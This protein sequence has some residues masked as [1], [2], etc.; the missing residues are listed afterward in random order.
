M[1]ST[2][3]KKVVSDLLYRWGR[4]GVT[5][6]GLSIGLYGLC[7]VLVAFVFLANDLNANFQST[8]PPNLIIQAQSIDATLEARIAALP[9]V[10]R[11]ERRA[12]VSGR[13]EVAPEQWIPLVLFV[14]DSFDEQHVARFF[15]E[16]DSW[17]AP[18]SIAIERDS[19]FFVRT[20]LETTLRMRLDGRSPVEI[21]APVSAYTYDPGQAPSRMELAVF[22]Y[23]QRETLAAWGVSPRYDRLIATVRGATAAGGPAVNS[24]ARL[25]AS[26][27]ETIFQTANLPRPIL[28]VYDSPE[29]PHQFQLDA[30]VAQLG[31][32]A[33]VSLLLC[34]MLVVNLIDS[35]MAAERRKIG[36]MR[37]IGARSTQI[38]TDYIL[39]IGSLGLLSCLMS[40]AFAVENGQRLAAGVAAQLNFDLLSETAPYWLYLAILAIGFALPAV[41]ALL[42]IVRTVRTPVRVALA[43]SD[44]PEHSVSGGPI[45]AAL[46]PLPVIPRMAARAISTRPRRATLTAIALSLGLVFFIGALNIQTSLWSTV[47]SVSRTKPFDV[48]VSLR[49]QPQPET[50]ASWASV[51]DNLQRTETWPT[52]SATLTDNGLQI[53]NPT[54]VYGVPEGS[55][56]I[57]PDLIAG[58]WIDSRNVA[59]VVVTQRL[60]EEQP[61]VDVGREYMLRIGQEEVSIRVVGVVRDFG[62][63]VIY[64]TEGLFAR[65]SSPA[66]GTTAFLELTEHDVGA[67]D[68]ARQQ[69]EIAAPEAGL[70][71]ANVAT[72][73]RLSAIVAAHLDGIVQVLAQVAAIALAVGGLALVSSL[74][75][76]V[77]ER[78]REVGVLKAIGGGHWSVVALFVAE[79]VFIA[80]IGWVIAVAV[81]PWVSQ[82][83]GRIFG[84]VIIQYPFDYEPHP[85]GP[86]AAFCTAILIAIA[87]TL[88]PVRS[89]LSLTIYRALRAQ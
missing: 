59:G 7:S 31:G 66:S 40:L 3:L 10:D 24:S 28:E 73:A 23:V 25:A 81:A 45:A 76:S 37:A 65:F 86:I 15:Q 60:L 55:W 88:L 21:E 2:R 12:V 46:R 80:V 26:E 30:M 32:V 74:S 34:V 58:D 49:G 78:Y 57:R 52:S 1:I 53:V 83:I 87:A 63:S 14:V 17:P 42:R 79:A 43:H 11:L 50:I 22:G 70:Q 89:A 64:A 13:I 82:E 47:E 39:G 72:S 8:N 38:A 16:S 18:N 20:P 19:R 9:N 62:P 29:H 36:V 4:T 67:Q 41:I 54:L 84:T 77:V 44:L 6:A 61:L 75:V 71:I 68:F 56:S 33:V 69:L 48:M 51:V 27:V 5:V 85:W 35:L